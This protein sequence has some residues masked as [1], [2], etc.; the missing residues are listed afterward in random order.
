MLCLPVF[1]RQPGYEADNLKAHGAVLSCLAAHR[2]LCAW[3]SLG[4]ARRIPSFD[5]HFSSW[6]VALFPRLA[7]ATRL[8]F[9]IRAYGMSARSATVLTASADGPSKKQKTTSSSG[10]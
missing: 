5:A 4:S 10:I 8:D 1:L 3:S 6:L 9:T 2:E 7:A